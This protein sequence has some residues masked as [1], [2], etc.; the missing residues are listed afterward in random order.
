MHSRSGALVESHC[1]VQKE[2]VFPFAVPKVL[3]LGSDEASKAGG[4]NYRGRE[5]GTVM[6]DL[7]ELMD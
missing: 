2:G 4:R 1:G 5:E 6:T 7:G 3:M